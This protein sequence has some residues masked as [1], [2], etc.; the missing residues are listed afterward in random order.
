MDEIMSDLS[1][2]KPVSIASAV[3]IFA[4][5][6]SADKIAAYEIIYNNLT[7]YGYHGWAIL[8]LIGFAL[9]NQWL[10]I[11]MP[12]RAKNLKDA[13]EKLSETNKKLN[14]MILQWQN[15]TTHNIRLNNSTNPQNAFKAL[16]WLAKNPKVLQGV[17]DQYTKDITKG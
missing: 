12:E 14:E 5:T 3:I 16:H 10:A 1:W 17:V 7:K 15:I 9:F 8:G 11:G 13:H 4:T 6:L 2:V